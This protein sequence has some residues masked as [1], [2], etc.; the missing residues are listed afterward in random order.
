MKKYIYGAIIFVFLLVLAY[1]F[2]FRFNTKKD[3]N[4]YKDLPIYTL[5]QLKNYDGTKPE[6]PIYIGLDG[7]VYDVTPGK[8]FYTPGGTYHNIAGTDATKELQIFGGDI[9]KTKYKIIGNLSQ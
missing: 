1:I 3:T 5:E 8:S 2:F 6:L 4:I 9:I 7:Y